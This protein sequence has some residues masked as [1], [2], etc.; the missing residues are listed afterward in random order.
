[1]LTFWMAIWCANITLVDWYETLN[2]RFDLLTYGLYFGL[3]MTPPAA[4]MGII[5]GRPR[6]GILCGL[7]STCGYML[8]WFFF[9]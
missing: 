6:T 4:M 5:C 8:M 3:V 7:S 2:L 9:A 1:M